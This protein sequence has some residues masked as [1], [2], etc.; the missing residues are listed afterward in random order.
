M[1]LTFTT[2]PLST[3]A[4]YISSG[5]R[6]FLTSKARDNKDAIGWEARAQYRGKPLSGPLVV[7]IALYWPDKRRHDVDNIK[8]LLDALTGILWEDDSQIS[9]LNLS[10]RYGD[11][12]GIHIRIEP[13]TGLPRME[14]TIR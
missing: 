10:K 7:E 5:G 6:R 4:L 2:L 12:P 13:D 3:N 1:T 14:V 9:T 8:A 11:A